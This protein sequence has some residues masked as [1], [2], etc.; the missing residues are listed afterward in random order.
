MYFHKKYH[1]S[2]NTSGLDRKPFFRHYFWWPFGKEKKAKPAPVRPG[3]LSPE[4]V[5]QQIK[6]YDIGTVVE[7]QR[8]G[9]DGTTD[10]IPVVV[11]ISEISDTGF[12]GKIVNV[13]RDLIEEQTEKLVFAKLGGGHIDFNYSDG[14]IK[15]ISLSSDVQTISESRDINNLIE[16]LSALEIGDKIIVSYYDQEQ[17]GSVTADGTLL[18]KTGDNKTFRMMLENINKI[19]L[20]KKIEKVFNIEE[21]LV[22]DVGII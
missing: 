10:D 2:S 22:M 13:E 19:E 17:H 12:S 16:V 20:E 15:D 3:A 11:E 21:D 14:D 5:E 1:D 6:G 18:S 7:I 4:K 9:F 8:I